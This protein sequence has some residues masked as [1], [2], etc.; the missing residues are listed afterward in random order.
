MKST[1]LSWPDFVGGILLLIGLLG[2][3]PGPI[4]YI[5]WLYEFHQA[6]KSELI[7]IGI[8]VILIDN[9]N[10]IIRRNEEKK[11]LILQ[12]GSPENAF[13]IEAARQLRARGWLFDGS[14]SNASIIWFGCDCDSAGVYGAVCVCVIY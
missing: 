2:F 9:A 13:A 6:I 3:I 1:T 12:M 5:P 10:E 14:I 8:A 7:G 4:P 11:R